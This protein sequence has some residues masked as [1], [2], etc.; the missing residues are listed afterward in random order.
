MSLFPV[1]IQPSTPLPGPLLLTLLPYSCVLFHNASPHETIGAGIYWL[2]KVSDRWARVQKSI[3]H[4]LFDFGRDAVQVGAGA[5]LC[6]QTQITPF[7]SPSVGTGAGELDC[8][9]SLFQAA[10][11]TVLAHY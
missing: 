6:I 11:G 3:Q 10:L 9:Y 8:H 1:T 2:Y 5:S 4:Q 7:N